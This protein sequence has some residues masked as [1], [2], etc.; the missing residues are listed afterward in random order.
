[1]TCPKCGDLAAE[2]SERCESCGTHL[3]KIEYGHGFGQGQ[4][5][6]LPANASLCSVQENQP[7]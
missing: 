7:L 6:N 3:F 4:K 2:E 5:S 1:M